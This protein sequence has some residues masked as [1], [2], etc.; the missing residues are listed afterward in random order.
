MSEEKKEKSLKNYEYI[1]YDVD[2]E[3]SEELRLHDEFIPNFNHWTSS[4]EQKVKAE[5]IEKITDEK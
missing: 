5:E 3:A 4:H 1:N 2:M